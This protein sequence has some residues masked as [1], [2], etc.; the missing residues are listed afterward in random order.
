[1][2]TGSRLLPVAL[3]LVFVAP[4]HAQR[5]VPKTDPKFLSAFKEVVAKAT[6]S[7]VRILCEGKEVALGTIVSPDGYI[8]TKASELKPKPVCKTHDGKDYPAKVVGVEPKYDLAMLKIEASGLPVIAWQ[9]SKSASVGNWLASAGTADLPVAVGVVSVATRKPNRFDMPVMPP[10]SDA[11][12]L[13]VGLEP[14]DLGAKISQVV[15]KGPAEK[16]GLKPGDVVVAVGKSKVADPERLVSLIQRLKPGTEVVLKVKRGEEELELKVKLEKRPS[17]PGF[18]R[19]DFQNR[20]GSAL[21]IRRGGFPTILQ[22]DTVIKPADCG[23]PL[24]DLDGKCVGI[25]I[26]R[27]GRTE[28]YAI[29]AEAVQSLLPEL[30]SGKLAPKDEARLQ[31][32]AELEKG[33]K[34]AEKKLAE[35]E[36][37]GDK[38]QLDDAKKKL[39]QAKAAFD[40]FKSEP[41]EE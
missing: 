7:T 37:K 2:K 27:A 25:N 21:S 20:M 4:V 1:M 15:S 16:A 39:E 26:A 11:G 36:K 8:I 33:V 35:V 17:D 38:K 40:K 34:E 31:K 3:L 32:L 19:A 22:H 10:P 30:K 5:L 24:V 12:F 28:S 6:Q 29:P 13:G 41:G 23:G 18:N 14:A 9:D